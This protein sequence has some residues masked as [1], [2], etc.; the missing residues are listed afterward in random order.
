MNSSK[1]GSLK[2]NS[3]KVNSSNVNR[4]NIEK[5]IKRIQNTYKKWNRT[6]TVEQMRQDWD[7][8]F[9]CSN[10]P[11]AIDD[12]NIDHLQARWIRS[13][14]VDPNKVVLYLHGGGFRMGSIDSHL[15]LTSQISVAAGI[16]LV[17]INY[18]L[19]PEHIFPEPLEDVYLAYQWL[20][21]NNYSANNIYVAGDSAGGNLAAA[22]LLLLKDNKVSLPGAAVL[23]SPWLDMH[24][25][26]ESYSS[27][28][29]VDPIHQR[30]F[31]LALAKKYLGDEGELTNPLASPL[32]GDLSDLPPILIQIGDHEVGLDES[33]LFAEKARK[34][35]SQVELQIYP[36]MI[37]VFQQHSNE[38]PEGV[39][40]IERI[41]EFLKRL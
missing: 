34:S 17:A 20:L 19:G 33:I 3:S 31:L 2:V 16:S 23:L 32:L 12:F 6:T 36:E 10:I 22:L 38:L 21:N 11:A 26:A 30:K 27:R 39:A 14:G 9:K 15:E 5:V 13:E 28:A 7:E 35:G 29:A 37:H 25:D 4:S 40:A 1:V 18:R 8:L 41:G 24:C